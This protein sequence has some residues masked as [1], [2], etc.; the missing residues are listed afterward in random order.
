MHLQAQ[1]TVQWITAAAA[2]PLDPLASQNAFQA[3][4]P[5]ASSSKQQLVAANYYY[6][7]S[8]Q[9]AA[10]SSRKQ[11]QEQAAANSSK[12]QH[13]VQATL[14]AEPPAAMLVHCLSQLALPS[15]AMHLL[16]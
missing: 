9:Q 10:T 11:Q 4:L 6:Y 1:G 8:E 14:S 2:W 5:A 12:Q 7:S 16:P 15:R 13:A 3:T